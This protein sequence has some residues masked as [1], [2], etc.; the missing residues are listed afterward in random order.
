MAFPGCKVHA[1]SL[2]HIDQKALSSSAA[3]ASRSRPLKVQLVDPLQRDKLLAAAKQLKADKSTSHI[4]ISRWLSKEEQVMS[5]Y[6][7][8]R[9]SQLNDITPRL[10]DGK[11]AFIVFNNEVK[12]RLPYGKLKRVPDVAE[13]NSKSSSSPAQS[14]DS[15]SPQ[16]AASM[17]DAP[18]SISKNEIGGDNCPLQ[19]SS[20]I[21]STHSAWCP[22]YQSRRLRLAWSPRCQPR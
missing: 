21:S 22:L 13:N 12:E 3:T 1:V 15:C 10:A 4:R 7:R 2:A 14:S 18:Q 16:P 20:P 11:L 8:Q 6:A 17:V 19:V 5:K 9:C